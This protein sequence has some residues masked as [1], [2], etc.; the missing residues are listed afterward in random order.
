MELRT[1]INALLGVAILYVFFR[2]VSSFL[3]ARCNAAKARDLG[4]KEPP[5]EINRWP[6]GIDSVRRS[7]AADRAQQFPADVLQ[8]FEELGTY[9]YRYNVLGR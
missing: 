4:C 8:R 2:L 5:V 6:F 7:L 3:T 9:T 1:V